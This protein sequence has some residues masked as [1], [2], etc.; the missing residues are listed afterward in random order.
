MENCRK[1]SAM[2]KEANTV[3]IVEDDYAL[4]SSLKDFLQDCG[5]NVAGPSGTA[6]MAINEAD[7][8]HID[9]AIVDI[10]LIGKIDGLMVG[11]ELADRGVR[12]IYLSG[13]FYIRALQEGRSHATDILIKPVSTEELLMTLTKALSQ[14]AA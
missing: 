9:A 3:L 11:S 14:T 6:E 12:V 2:D 4:A 7:N 1:N 10:G 13:E 8:N 5:Y